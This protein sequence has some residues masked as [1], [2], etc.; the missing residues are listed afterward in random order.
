MKI[1]IIGGK[2]TAVNIADHI[3]NAQRVHGQAIEFL[4][5]A[6]D[7]PSLKDSIN[8]HPIVC[9][10]D[11]LHSIY[12]KYS[13]VKFIFSLYKPEKMIERVKLLKSY[14]IPQGKF[15]TFVH[16]TSY[17]SDHV[18][19]GV[20][21][22][23]LSNCSINSNVSIGD[24]NIINSNVVIEHDSSIGN[25]N[26]IAATTCV[27]SSVEIKNGTFIGLNSSIREKTVIHNFSFVGIG[28]N[29]LN[30]VESGA[31]VYGNPAKERKK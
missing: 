4:G 5:Y 25:N 9:T 22:A 7:D 15:H 20:G 30:D 10:T 13:D 11:K 17:V 23:I 6:I 24:Y 19:L 16:P 28:S 14:G 3:I 29:V 18:K 21:N 12:G 26:F 27:G 1:I 31:V 8:G 2:G